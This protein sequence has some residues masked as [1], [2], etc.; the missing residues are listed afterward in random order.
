M[1]IRAAAAVLFFGRAWQHLSGNSLFSAFFW[2][3]SLLKPL[4]ENFFLW[5]W[6]EYITNWASGA[7][8]DRLSFFV[9]CFYGLAFFAIILHHR[10]PK[11]SK[12]VILLAMIGLIMQS[13]LQFFDSAYAW[14]QMLEMGIQVATPWVLLIHTSHGLIPKRMIWI[15]IALAFTFIG[16]GIYAYGIGW[17]QPGHFISMTMNILHLSENNAALFLKIMGVLD[18]L[19]GL[20]LFIPKCSRVALWYMAA[21]GLLTALARPVAHFHFEFWQDSLLIWLPEMLYRLPHGLLPLW[22]MEGRRQSQ[23][24]Q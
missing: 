21:W 20:L 7:F 13:L 17:P 9:G 1:L 5:S 11:F 8:L 14:P 6:Q 15:K 16:H 19:A 24:F 3:E 2:D 22:T 4:V 23:Y 18:G 12:P 10:F